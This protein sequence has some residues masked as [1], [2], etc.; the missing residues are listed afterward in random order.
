MVL[1]S[2][3]DKKTEILVRNVVW[4]GQPPLICAVL[5]NSKNNCNNQLVWVIA[6]VAASQFLKKSEGD[7]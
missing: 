4:K 2:V 7:R 1:E 3:K 5:V 6:T